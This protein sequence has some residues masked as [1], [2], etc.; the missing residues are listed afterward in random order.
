MSAA[1]FAFAFALSAADTHNNLYVIREKNSTTCTL[2]SYT[3]STGESRGRLQEN[4][5]QLSL[6]YRLPHLLF[7]RQHPAKKGIF[8]FRFPTLCEI[9]V[10]PGWAGD[11]N[12][13]AATVPAMP[14]PGK[15]DDANHL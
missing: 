2:K 3:Q 1:D 12:V 13:R 14:R 7:S 5:L 15:N 4:H 11:L 10:N 6:P 8:G 9:Y